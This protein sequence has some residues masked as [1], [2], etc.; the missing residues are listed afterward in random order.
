MTTSSQLAPYAAAFVRRADAPATVRV[1]KLPLSAQQRQWVESAWEHLDVKKAIDIDVDLVN[2][3]S[4][5]GYEREV[6]QFVSSYWSRLGIHSY[7]QQLDPQQGNAVARLSGDGS[8]ATL[9][10]ACPIDTHW[11]GRPEEDGLQWGDPMRR[12]NMRPAVV[13][14]QTIVG[15][16]SNNDKGLATAIMMAVEAVHRAGVPLKGAL[17]ASTLAGGAP[18]LSPPHE[19]RKNISLCSGVWHLLTQGHAADFALYHKPGYHVSWEEPGMCYFRIRVKGDPEYMAT[20]SRATRPYRVLT[21]TAR[22]IVALDQWSQRYLESASG[23]TARPPMAVGSVRAGAPHKP[24]WS[25]AIS[26]IFLD[27][28]PAPWTSPSEINHLFHDV[29]SGILKDNPGMNA[30]WEMFVSVP[31]GRTDPNSWIVQSAIR[32]AQAVEGTDDEVYEGRRAGQTEAGIIRT[33]G[34]PTAR[35]SGAPPNPEMP[36]DLQRGFTMSGAYAPNIVKAA[37][38]FCYS[39]VDTL[40]R[41]R[42]E[43][44]LEY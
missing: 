2:I 43:V 4:P 31:G 34:I 41:S 1:K 42:E 37:Q 24:N 32:A 36:Q 12:D 7:Y 35:V 29:M 39:I 18:A 38:A 17:I 44:G 10:L 3:Y 6:N 26:E 40:T 16:G 11:T 33:M 23:G 22:I 25:P 28:R 5:T 20:E 27:I 30:E 8:G 13:E 14:G 21:D 19:P 9:L 15:L